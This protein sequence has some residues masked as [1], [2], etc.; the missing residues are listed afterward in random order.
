MKSLKRTQTKDYIIQAIRNEI[1]SGNIPSGEELA[2]E[3]LADML[4]IS[5]MPVREALQ[6]LVEEGF[7]KR[8][9]N[10]HIQAVVLNKEQIRETLCV[11]G[12]AEAETLILSVKK[13][14]DTGMLGTIL[15]KLEETD[16]LAE[17][18]RLELEFHRAVMELPD[19]PYLYQIQRKVLEG[20]VAYGI[21]NMGDKDEVSRLLEKLVK[22]VEAGDFS[23]IRT[24]F[25]NYYELYAN[26]FEGRWT[27]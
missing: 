19:N 16:D 24:C 25:E 13:G 26:E 7:A 1:L 22:A 14:A 2:Q 6:A 8:L 20:Y 12:T 3:T 17:K 18:A 23:E 9:P 21:E 11:M 10:R 5:R 27:Q 4:G 15:A